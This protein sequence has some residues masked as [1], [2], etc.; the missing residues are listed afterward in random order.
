MGRPKSN[1]D[2]EASHVEQAM[3]ALTGKERV[4]VTEYA[5]DGDL[6]RSARE[7]G[8]LGGKPKLRAMGLRVLK[9]PKVQKA[10]DYLKRP[11]LKA[12]RLTIEEVTAQLSR[13]LYRNVTPY[14]DEEGRLKC[15]LGDLP[16]DL[17]QAVEGI[18]VRRRKHYTPEGELDYIEEDIDL[19]FVSKAA[20]SKLVMS[21]LGML[22]PN[23]TN[24]QI[25]VWKDMYDRTQ[26][27]PPNIIDAQI[28]KAAS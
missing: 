22:Q 20:I 13:F 4:F 28:A 24:V 2:Y 10:L 1:L 5:A 18:K 21:H 19:M 3:A 11:A 8:Y 12:A 6:E 7:A 14:C 23:T 26:E 15:S 16:E 9:K 17:Q 25:N 27:L